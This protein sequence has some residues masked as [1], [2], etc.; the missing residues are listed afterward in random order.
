MGAKRRHRRQVAD[1]AVEHVLTDDG[2]DRAR[3][4]QILL[5]AAVDHRVFRY[6]D[7][8]RQ[9]VR[10][11]V[12]N[13]RYRR[14]DV[15]VVLR[16]VDRIVGGDVQVIEILGNRE[17]FGYIGEVAVLRGGQ[18]LDLAVTLR[19][20]DRLLRPYARIDV[21]GLPTEEVG[22][23]LVKHRAG[24]AAHVEDLIVVGHMQQ[25][26][27]QRVG[28]GHHRVE[29]LRA[30]R[31]RKQGETRAVE[32]ENRLG[33]V[34]DNHIRQDRRAGVEIVLLDHD[35]YGILGFRLRSVSLLTQI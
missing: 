34:A 29:I 15:L 11:H 32:I 3:R 28:F 12:G 25:L 22:S 35:S 13:Q 30:V 20:L 18:H 4:R 10:R 19:L 21:T 27:E 8:T 9:D 2:E 6:V 23:H 1:D 5:G 26:A 31:D 16:A 33:G 24:A 17:P 14:I 7:R